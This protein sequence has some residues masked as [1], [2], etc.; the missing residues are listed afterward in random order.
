[1]PNTKVTSD[2]SGNQVLHSTGPATVYA[3]PSTGQPIAITNA[4]NRN[5]VHGQ[6]LTGSVVYGPVLD[7][8]G[9]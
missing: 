3:P 2:N 8:P 6:I 7:N 9:R 1:M 4:G 5:E